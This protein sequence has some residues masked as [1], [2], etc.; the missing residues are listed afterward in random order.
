MPWLH[1]TLLPMSDNKE[2]DLDF[3]N[4]ADDLDLGPWS[5]RDL[6]LE[7]LW[8][9]YDHEAHEPCPH[10]GEPLGDESNAANGN[11]PYR[12]IT[13]FDPA[14]KRMGNVE[15]A[16]RHLSR[17]ELEAAIALAS[18]LLRKKWLD[19]GEQQKVPDQQGDPDRGKG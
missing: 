1:E 3:S 9:L 12:H 11:E 2:A 7:E 6:D 15:Y 17:L 19:Q 8:A 10:C 18:E 4:A 5:D 13:C 16:L 14:E